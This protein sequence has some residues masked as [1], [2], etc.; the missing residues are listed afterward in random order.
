MFKESIILH[1]F[2]SNFPLSIS[3][4]LHVFGFQNIWLTSSW[5]LYKALSIVTI[6]DLTLIT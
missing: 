3:W 2:V 1:N 5:I 4:I 6:S